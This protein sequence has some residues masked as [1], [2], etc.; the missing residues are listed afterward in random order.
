[1]KTFTVLACFVIAAGAATLSR[2]SQFSVDQDIPTDQRRLTALD[3]E[4]VEEESSV[5]VRPGRRRSKALADGDMP[6]Q[7]S[8][9]LLE[10]RIKEAESAVVTY[11]KGELPQ[12]VPL[13]SYAQ[14]RPTENAIFGVLFSRTMMGA[15]IKTFVGSA[16]RHFDGDI[17]IAIFPGLRA[18]LMDMFKEFNVVLYEIHLD[19][20]KDSE[21]SCRFL[22]VPEMDPMPVAQV[23][24]YLYWQWAKLYR[25]SSKIMIADTRDVLFQLNPFEYNKV[26]ITILNTF[27]S[28]ERHFLSQHEWQSSHLVLFLEVGICVYNMEAFNNFCAFYS[29]IQIK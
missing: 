26:N 4:G 17:V 23:R 10:R 25:S 16:R 3:V 24:Y 21:S 22:N 18:K 28:N 6:A 2:S 1:M 27:D 7:K 8:P 5:E 19:C 14:H 13:S 15:D 29:F 20:G 12:L 9:V 11:P